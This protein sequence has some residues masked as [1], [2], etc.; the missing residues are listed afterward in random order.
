MT[1]GTSNGRETTVSP[2]V[3][4]HEWPESDRP[5]ERLINRGAVSLSDSELVALLIGSGIRGV[6]AVDLAKQL[7]LHF[8]GLQPL[9][10]ADPPEITR[11]HGIGSACAARLSAAFELGRRIT[12]CVPGQR[13]TISAPSDAVGAYGHRLRAL[14]TE[15]FQVLL[16]NN[17]NQVIRHQTVTTG[18][19]NA[20]L[21]HPR[22]V[23]KAA[24][25]HRSA[26]VILM[27]NHPSG[28]RQPSPEDRRVTRQMIQ[29]GDIMGIPVVDHIIIAGDAYY[30]FAEEGGLQ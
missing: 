4:L 15:T 26:G 21:V 2:H 7:L 23:F 9:S 8:G 24:V 10:S 12:D 5:R 19:L 13:M 27:H 18:T 29:A 17:A 3:R 6:T 14:K 11:L 28:N 20:S 1:K 22:E 25:D 16:L 30:S